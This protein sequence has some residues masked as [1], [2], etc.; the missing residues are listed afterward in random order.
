MKMME[1]IK[2]IE[3]KH[4][5][6]HLSG[7]GV[8]EVI[9]AEKALEL[10]FS[11]EYRNYLMNYGAISFGSH[12]FTGLGVDEYIDVVLATK[13]EKKLNQGIPNDCILIENLGIEGILILQDSNGVIYSLDEKG[14][15]E[16]IANSFSVY[17]KS[18]I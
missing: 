5:V 4:K 10:T 13:E 18:L 11:E 7:C 16:K 14:R 8:E 2:Q 1:V 6:Y 12:E 17:M 3:A 9:A 15:L